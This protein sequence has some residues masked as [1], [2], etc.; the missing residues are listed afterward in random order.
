MNVRSIIGPSS[1]GGPG[2]IEP[3][4]V[5]KLV[6]ALDSGVRRL[7][8][9]S[10]HGVERADKLPFNLRN[11]FG[12]LDKQRAAEQEVV[13]KVRLRVRVGCVLKVCA[14]GEA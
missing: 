8:I 5:P 3:D 1:A 9:V 12:Q 14:Q 11:V 6:K 7:V 13:L 4:V 10:T 2:G